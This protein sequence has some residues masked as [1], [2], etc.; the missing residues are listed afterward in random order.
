MSQG[1][2]LTPGAQPGPHG[3]GALVV[4]HVLDV[5]AVIAAAAAVQDVIYCSM[6]SGM[7]ASLFAGLATRRTRP[8]YSKAT[9]SFVDILLL[10]WT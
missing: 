4:V 7:V 8:S 5:T 2:S 9:S 10:S 3:W 1:R 6:M